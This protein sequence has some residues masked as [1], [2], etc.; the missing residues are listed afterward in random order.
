MVLG[1]GSSSTGAG[2]GDGGDAHPRTGRVGVTCVPHLLVI[3]DNG[4]VYILHLWPQ[5]ETSPVDWGPQVQH[6]RSHPTNYTLTATA[7]PPSLMV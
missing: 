6:G 7:W 3:Q 1:Q 2:L 4:Q 5:K